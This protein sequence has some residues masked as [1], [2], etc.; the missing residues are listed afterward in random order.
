MNTDDFSW[1][2]RL[3]AALRTPLLVFIVV[4]MS[5]IWNAY[6]KIRVSLRG[7]QL[8]T[9]PKQH[10]ERVEYVKEQLEKWDKGGRKGR[11][12]TARPNWRASTRLCA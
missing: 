3:A 1:Q 9:E 12:R 4:P 5:G 11:L 10:A 8:D 6:R 7:A 2:F